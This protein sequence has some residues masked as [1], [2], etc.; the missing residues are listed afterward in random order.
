M[1]YTVGGYGVSGEQFSTRHDTR[2]I[3]ETTRRNWLNAETLSYLAMGV[4]AMIAK[5]ERPT[6]AG[7]RLVGRVMMM[8]GEAR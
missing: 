1:R 8:V 6:L 2:T 7:A 4:A 3:I 5:A